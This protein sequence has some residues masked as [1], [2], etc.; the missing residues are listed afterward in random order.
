MVLRIDARERALLAV[1]GAEVG[2]T[3]TGDT[4]AGSATGTGVRGVMGVNDGGGVGF[5]SVDGGGVGV[6][7]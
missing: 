5:S 3:L 6:H 1:C 7:I 2:S 4:V